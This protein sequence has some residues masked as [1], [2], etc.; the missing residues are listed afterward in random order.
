MHVHPAIA[1]LR[2]DYASQRRS[3]AAMEAALDAWN[4]RNSIV[5]IRR[6][7][8]EFAWGQ[9]LAQLSALASLMS[10]HAQTQVFVEQFCGEFLRALREELLGEVPMRH[11]SS[12]GFTRLQIMQGLNNR[13]GTATLSLCVYEP[14]PSSSFLPA[15][16]QF[17][18]CETY[19][20]VVAGA[21][22]G[23]FHR[24]EC[25][26]A[27]AVADTLTSRACR[28]RGGDTIAP[29]GQCEARQICKVDRSFLV[30]QLSRMPTRAQASREYRIS[31]GALLRQ[32]S[33]DK[34]ASQHVLAM[35]VLGALEHS[36]AISPMQ[37]YAANLAHDPD[38]RW[39]AARQVLALDAACGFA[40]L[41]ALSRAGNDPLAK[42]A[43]ELR[44][45]L[46][47]MHP[48]FRS[49]AEEAV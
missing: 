12:A 3:K 37:A 39:E 20:M 23:L 21:A 9:E 16:V 22:S 13:L 33:G 38:A 14:L 15:A 6:E 11:G 48:A 28:W 49:S 44:E 5:A 26:D 42:P 18:D 4:N 35:A 27:D 46:L 47:I 34:R 29:Q 30:L 24:L 8:A 2:S 1:A 43:F 41:S 31:D 32:T 25:T 7:L 45:N 10:D 40:L 19:E 36:D 17:S